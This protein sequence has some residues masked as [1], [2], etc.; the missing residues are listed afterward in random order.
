M[1]IQPILSKIPTA[2]NEK[3]AGF[4]E[5]PEVAK[6]KNVCKDLS[7]VK[8][9]GVVYNRLDLS[10]KTVTSETLTSLGAWFASLGTTIAL[11]VLVLPS[12]SKDAFS[13][14]TYSLSN[15]VALGNQFCVKQITIQ[16]SAPYIEQGYGEP[17]LSGGTLEQMIL[18]FEN[19][20]CKLITGDVEIDL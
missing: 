16:T 9:T 4:L 14:S 20:G 2:L 5:L 17:Q 1:S 19:G 11:K 3:I 15:A 18:R 10:N 6:L 12:M 13:S 8:P 7:K